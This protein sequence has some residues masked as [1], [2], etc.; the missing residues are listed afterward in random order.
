[1]WLAEPF[2]RGQAWV[3]MIMLANHKNGYIRKRGVRVT[4]SR[5]QLG[6]SERELATRWRWSRGK[7]RRFFGELKHDGNIVPQKTNV[8]SLI[9][10]VNYNAYQG[11][12]TT[13][14]P[15]TGHKQYQNNNG[16]NGK[17]REGG[18]FKP[19]TLTE[20]TAYCKQRKNNINPKVFL[21][22]NASKGWMIGKNKMRDWKAALRTWEQRNK[23]EAPG[24]SQESG[25]QKCRNCGRT[26][27]VR[28]NDRG[29][30]EKCQKEDEDGK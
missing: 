12:S 5:G 28:L 14:G 10:I 17:K 23:D 6:W 16:K 26:D 2:T 8:T 24:T 25:P 13:D 21:D 30:C 9:N 11:N 27:W 19:P 1:M 3:D 7:V 20:V 22:W 29:Q 18:A 4:V 15:Q